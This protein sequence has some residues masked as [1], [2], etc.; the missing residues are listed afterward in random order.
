MDNKS[1]PPVGRCLKR[2]T[3]ECCVTV[4]ITNLCDLFE[5][6]KKNR[7]GVCCGDCSNFVQIKLIASEKTKQANDD[8]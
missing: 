8:Q 2:S 7:Y 6:N 4:D 5:P 3:K 1:Q